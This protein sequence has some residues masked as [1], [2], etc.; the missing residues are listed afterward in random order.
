MLELKAHDYGWKEGRFLLTTSSLPH[1]PVSMLST[2]TRE[3]QCRSCCIR[4]VCGMRGPLLGV[5]VGAAKGHPVEGVHILV[6][7]V[8]RVVETLP[9]VPL[10][11]HLVLIQVVVHVDVGD[12]RKGQTQ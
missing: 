3:S 6:V 4:S 11:V 1:P 9:C 5:V 12:R 7:V 2:L 10:S 8:I